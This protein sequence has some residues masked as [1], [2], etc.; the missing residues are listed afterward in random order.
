MDKWMKAKRKK[1]NHMR[2]RVQKE[3]M[4]ENKR[5]RKKK[6][7]WMKAKKVKDRK[8]ERKKER[9]NSWMNEMSREKIEI[10]RVKDVT[11]LS[12]LLE[13][14]KRS[15]IFVLFGFFSFS[16]YRIHIAL[17]KVNWSYK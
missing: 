16:I 1:E 2:H 4:K 12:F 6:N 17:V 10:I 8:K 7:E 14:S 15:A 5:K 13:K 3:W 11:I 9:K